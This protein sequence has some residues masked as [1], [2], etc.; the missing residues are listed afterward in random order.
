MQ[1][2]DRFS[3]P[4]LHEC[5]TREKAQVITDAADRLRVRRDGKVEDDEKHDEQFGAV[6]RPIS[7]ELR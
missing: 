2:F 6:V 1:N 7:G 3:E 4:R 5:I